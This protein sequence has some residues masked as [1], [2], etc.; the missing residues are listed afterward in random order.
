MIRLF[1]IF[2]I[3]I[4][5]K[6]NIVKNPSFE[7]FDSKNKLT[8]WR[9]NNK[10]EISSDSH[11]GKNSL[12][13]KQENKRV[14]NYQLIELEK[15]YRYEICIH[16]KLKNIIGNGFSFYIDNNNYSSGINERYYSPLY[17]GTNDWKKECYDSGKIKKPNGDEEKYVFGAFTFEENKTNGE[18]FIDDISIYRID[19]FLKITISNDRD[20]VYDN[21]NIVYEIDTD[22][23]NYSLSDWNLI[24]RIKDGNINIYETRNDC[25]ISSFFTIPINIEKLNLINNHFYQIEVILSNLKDE[26]I[27]INNYTF[28]KI[29]KIERKVTFD[30]YGRMYLNN[31]LFFPFGIYL[32]GV[33]QNDLIQ[34]NRTHLNFIIPYSNISIDTMN[35]INET[36]NGNIKIIYSIRD[37]FQ[38]NSTTCNVLNEENDYKD[39]IKTINKLKEHPLLI[40]WYINDEISSCF[41]KN[42]RNRTLTIHEI[43]PNHPS[44]TVICKRDDVEPLINTTDIMGIDVYPIGFPRKTIRDVYEIHNGTY[45]KLLRT[46]PMWPVVQIFD[47]YWYFG[48][49]GF[50]SCPPTLQE[51]RSMSWQAFVS[52][53]KGIIFYSLY[54]IFRMNNSK[55]HRQPF[56]ERWGDVI[57]FTDQIWKYKDV[58]LSVEKVNYIEYKENSNAAFKQWKYNGY[59]YLVVVNLERKNEIFEINLLN[60]YKI[61]K[62]FGLGTFKQNKNNIIIYLEPIDVF[63][64]KYNIDNSS[65]FNF[66]IIIV[67]IILISIAMLIIFI[68][69][70]YFIKKENKSTFINKGLEPIIDE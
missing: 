38:I 10:T 52:G 4:N 26:I 46:K 9:I 47:W 70:R 24:T 25:I 54:D 55:I 30:E 58:I 42:L 62:E 39:Y 49:E 40:G 63:M 3:I 34:L 60:E 56:E 43:D 51:M 32:Y 12:H 61:N 14:K 17:N 5:C 67:L 23:G 59:N 69:K 20:E 44:L 50:E 65:N 31:E 35:M 27:N 57:E 2:F 28:K 1:F 19:D 7:E 48:N 11:S 64:I 53:A 15:N 6:D 21:I 29:E 41:N 45:N 66:T 8:Y 16:F 22:K 13:W 36:Q 33:N 18:V 68:I 37:I